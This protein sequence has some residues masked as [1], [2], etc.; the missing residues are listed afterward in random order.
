MTHFAVIVLIL[1]AEYGLAMAALAWL[2]RRFGASRRQ[3]VFWG[4]TAF[5]LLSGIAVA[6]IWPLDVS[7]V[8]NVPGVWLGDWLYSHAIEWIGD[9]RSDQ[10]HF[11]IPWPL[12]VP[13]VYV[14][15]SAGWCALLGLL[16]SR[17]FGHP[18]EK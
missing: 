11:T 5:G 7:A 6:L 4:C 12:R 18:V 8:I 2:I 10:A 15:T 9:P 1:V 17:L 3:A 16:L 14:I 13:Q